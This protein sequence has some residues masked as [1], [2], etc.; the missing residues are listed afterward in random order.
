[1]QQ[2]TALAQA[3]QIGEPAVGGVVVQMRRR[4]HDAGQAEIPRF[5]QIGPARRE[6]VHH[7]TQ[8]LHGCDRIAGQRMSQRSSIGV[9]KPDT[10]ID[11]A[12]A[13]RS[14]IMRPLPHV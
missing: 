3:T 8:I 13:D 2:V 12:P 7:A 5:D 9:P 10:R 4:E 11:T 1:M 6:S 14:G